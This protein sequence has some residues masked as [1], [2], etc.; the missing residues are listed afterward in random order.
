MNVVGTKKKRH[1]FSGGAI[2]AERYV[3]DWIDVQMKTKELTRPGNEDA[4]EESG[5]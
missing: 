1:A 2:H 3:V 4:V 5:Y